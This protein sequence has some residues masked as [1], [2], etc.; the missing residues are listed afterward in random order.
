MYPEGLDGSGVDGGVGGMLD[1]KIGSPVHL[2][3]APGTTPV[4]TARTVAGVPTD[5]LTAI[6]RT[7]SS[8]RVRVIR[9]V[10]SAAAMV[11]VIT[12]VVAA[13]G[14]LVI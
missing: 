13:A 4:A 7:A 10:G 1:L 5:D 2:A 8:T 6:G 9:A 3:G 14:I 11:M 12:R